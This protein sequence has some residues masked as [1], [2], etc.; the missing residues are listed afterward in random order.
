[1]GAQLGQRYTA[2]RSFVQRQLQHRASRLYQSGLQR[3][4]GKRL[5]SLG[6]ANPA[7]AL[8][9]QYQFSSGRSGCDF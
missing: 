5:F 8:F 2:L 3:V 1:M 7:K 4:E 6:A 9:G